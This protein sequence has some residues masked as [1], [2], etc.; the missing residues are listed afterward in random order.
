[1]VSLGDEKRLRCLQLLS[2]PK[3]YFQPG[4]RCLSILTGQCIIDVLLVSR[5]QYCEYSRLQ[6]GRVKIIRTTY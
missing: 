4:H 6:G 5:G 3:A 1:M 2:M